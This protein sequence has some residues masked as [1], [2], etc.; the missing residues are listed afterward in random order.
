MTRSLYISM[1][2]LGLTREKLHLVICEAYIFR[3]FIMSTSEYQGTS[4]SRVTANTKA[5]TKPFNAAA[6]LPCLWALHA[7]N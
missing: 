4:K 2:R 6:R 7:K 3:L 5:S 1:A